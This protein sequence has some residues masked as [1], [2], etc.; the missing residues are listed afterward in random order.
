[1][2][3]RKAIAD[4]DKWEQISQQVAKR[5]QGDIW[6]V[7]DSVKLPDIWHEAGESPG[8]FE[9][10][11]RDVDYT[12]ERVILD[13]DPVVKQWIQDTMP[14]IRYPHI[15][16]LIQR[17]G[18]EVVDHWDCDTGW[19]NRCVPDD[20]NPDTHDVVRR[21]VFVTDW[22]EGQAWRFEDKL[23]TEWSAGTVIEWPWWSRHGTYNRS[24]STRI[25]IK[26]TGE[27]IR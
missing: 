19:L 26:I 5:N 3:H 14:D 18:K 8:I 6:R 11:E 16:W 20:H 1:M 12:L 9:S 10:P 24:D 25:N 22:R 2:D 23:L 4:K 17:P 7:L 21:V 15:L 13:G 27:R